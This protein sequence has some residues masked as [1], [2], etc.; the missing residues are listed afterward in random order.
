MQNILFDKQSIQPVTGKEEQQ[1]KTETFISSVDFSNAIE[2]LGGDLEFF[3]TLTDDYVDIYENADKTFADFLTIQDLEQAE[4]LA[5]NIAG[6]AGTFGAEKLMLIAR[7]VEQE[8]RD[9]ELSQESI[10]AFTQELGN[11][12]TA[13][14]DF[15]KFHERSTPAT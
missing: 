10:T 8:L 9:D 13:I 14:K 11:L 4:R 1:T 7:K 5:H 12:I 15:K 3:H 6:L 2:R